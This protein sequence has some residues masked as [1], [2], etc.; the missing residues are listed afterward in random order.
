MPASKRW[1]DFNEENVKQIP[2]VYGVYQFADEN[3]EIL[4]IGE[5]KLRH[6]ISIYLEES[7]TKTN[8]AYFRYRENDSKKSSKQRQSIVLKDYRE[9]HGKLPEFN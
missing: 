6:N 8:I 5:G 9:K 1:I 7:N 3:K 2:N 4:Y